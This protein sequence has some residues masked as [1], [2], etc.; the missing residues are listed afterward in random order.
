MSQIT[1]AKEEVV[2]QVFNP[3]AASLSMDEKE[4]EQ[5]IK[6]ENW[7]FRLIYRIRYELWHNSIDHVLLVNLSR[8]NGKMYLRKPNLFDFGLL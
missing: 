5:R 1:E 3:T 6:N 2:D 8:S 7:F 4:F